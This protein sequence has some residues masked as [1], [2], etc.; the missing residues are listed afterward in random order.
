MENEPRKTQR[1]VVGLLKNKT[2]TKGTG[3]NWD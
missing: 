1:L 3:G 2:E